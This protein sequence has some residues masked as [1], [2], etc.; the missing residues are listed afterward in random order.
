MCVPL[1]ERIFVFSLPVGFPG[2]DGAWPDVWHASASVRSYASGTSARCG[3][4]ATGASALSGALCE[5]LPVPAP[6]CRHPEPGGATPLQRNTHGERLINEVRDWSSLYQ[7][8]HEVCMLL[9]YF[10]SA[11]H[12]LMCEDPSTCN[13]RGYMSGPSWRSFPKAF[14]FVDKG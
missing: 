3:G 1:S 4:P 11:S 6:P 9:R 8:E 12:S 2:R 5:R 10:A 14:V 7:N 13:K